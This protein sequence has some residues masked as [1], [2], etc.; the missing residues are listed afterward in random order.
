MTVAARRDVVSP[1]TRRWQRAAEAIE[2]EHTLTRNA[3]NAKYVLTSVSLL[4]TLVSVIGL[5][6]LGELTRRPELLVFAALAVVLV[7]AAVL[8][9][10]WTLV[11]RSR[12][13]NLDDLEDVKAWYEGEFAHAGKV[14][15]AGRLLCAGLLVAGVT[16]LVAAVVPHPSYRVG[17]DGVRSAAQDRLTA[18]AGVTDADP[19][20]VLTMTVTGSDA[21][22]ANT[23]LTRSRGTP[24][25]DGA[26]TF[27]VSVDSPRNYA[28]YTVVLTA[29]GERV[30]ALTLPAP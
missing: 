21:S 12:R 19:D 23:V 11:L 8:L 15:A 25:A 20:A 26:A 17:L 18:S 7:L 14:A 27:R 16:A 24:D 13:V 29:D 22:G 30:A 2:P 10:L 9:A 4:G 3:A 5:A 6:S 1:E 28:T